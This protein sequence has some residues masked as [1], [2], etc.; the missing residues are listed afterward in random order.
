MCLRIMTIICREDYR[1]Q[2]LNGPLPKRSVPF[3]DIENAMWRFLPLT[4]IEIRS[5]VLRR[6]LAANGMKRHFAAVIGNKAMP[7]RR[8]APGIQSARGFFART[9]SVGEVG[10]SHKKPTRGCY[11]PSLFMLAGI[12]VAI[13]VSATIAIWRIR[14]VRRKRIANKNMRDYVRRAY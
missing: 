10:R 4:I 8:F 1:A 3:L 2:I 11:N 5:L 13:C 9:S 12:A 7:I 14:K 6:H